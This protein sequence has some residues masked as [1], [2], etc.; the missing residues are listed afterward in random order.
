MIIVVGKWKAKVMKMVIAVVLIVAFAALIP[1]VSGM[2]Y[3][4][5]PVFSSWFEDET[6]SGN[7]M[8]VEV[9]SQGNGVETQ[10][11]RFV[12]KVQNFYYEE[13]E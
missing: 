3:N 12:L 8:R 13:K 11:D 5:A 4:K 1:L 6:P 9:E 7:P 10:L 2:L